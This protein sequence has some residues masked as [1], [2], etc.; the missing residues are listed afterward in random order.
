MKKFNSAVNFTTSATLATRATTLSRMKT[1]NSPNMHCD[2][3]TS[4]KI[5]LGFVDLCAVLQIVGIVA[6]DAV[7]RVVETGK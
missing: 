4:H 2:R 3:Q 1:T 7:E 6:L 5:P